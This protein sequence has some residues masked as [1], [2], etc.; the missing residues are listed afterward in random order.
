M[1]QIIIDLQA[2]RGKAKMSHRFIL[3]KHKKLR[4]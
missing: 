2:V 1:D 4:K 3:N